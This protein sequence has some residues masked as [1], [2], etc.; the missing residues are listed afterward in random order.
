MG[1]INF[2]GIKIELPNF[3]PNTQQQ[4]SENT[5]SGLQGIQISM[6]GNNR[7]NQLSNSALPGGKVGGSNG[8]TNN[9]H[10]QN[11]GHLTLN[12][13]PAPLA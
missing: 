2:G 7:S 5:T 3:S 1:A 9:I 12:T 4:S 6:P 11:G 10:V 8:T 13:N